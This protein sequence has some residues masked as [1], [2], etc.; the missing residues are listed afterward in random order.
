MLSAVEIALEEG[1]HGPIQVSKEDIASIRDAAGF[2]AEVPAMSGG[3]QSLE[4]TA[5]ADRLASLHA[6][7]EPSVK[8]VDS[9]TA[10][11][12]PLKQQYFLLLKTKSEKNLESVKLFLLTLV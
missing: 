4:L 8:E 3:E 6:T 9:S 1:R 11:A 10:L 12:P 2:P 5:R 7:I